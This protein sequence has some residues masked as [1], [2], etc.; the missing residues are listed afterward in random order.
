MKVLDGLVG[1]NRDI[2]MKLLK[3]IEDST[4]IRNI[5]GMTKLFYVWSKK[6]I[7]RW[8]RCKVNIPIIFMSN[9]FALG[10]VIIDKVF[11]F[12]TGL[13][14]GIGYCFFLAHEI[15]RGIFDLV[16]ESSENS[17]ESCGVAHKSCISRLL[18]AL[19]GI[20]GSCALNYSGLVC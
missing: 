16:F 8:A 5:I 15:K 6:S 9:S 11:F 12:T 17:C 13:R 18:N 10:H 19:W 20:P 2:L 14:G 1:L 7:F 3:I 4:K